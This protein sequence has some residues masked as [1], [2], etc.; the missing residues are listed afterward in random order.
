MT[1]PGGWAGRLTQCWVR[2]YTRS[3]PVG[4]TVDRRAEMESDLWEQVATRTASGA[5][6]RRI[7]RELVGRALRGVPADVA[8][9]LEV[10]QTPGR[11]N[12]HVQHPSTVLLSTWAILLPINLVAD[13]V[14][15]DAKRWSAAGF[16]GAA[17]VALGA[18]MIAFVLVSLVQRGKAGLRAA[19]RSAR[20]LRVGVLC[21]MAVA[22]ASSGIWRFAPEPLSSISS[23]A[24]GA[25]G[26]LAIAY[27]LL[28]A[29]A[30][31]RRV[32]LD[33]RKIPS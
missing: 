33:V 26:L 29:Y 31:T 13:G 32:A 21:A 3:A 8:W 25:V 6:P 30:F 24:W 28:V 1:T 12:W 27:G 5:P 9:R 2:L 23:L 4:D 17:T 20:D 19:P 11:L 14:A 16:L 10:E 22:F 15:H 18:F 7:R